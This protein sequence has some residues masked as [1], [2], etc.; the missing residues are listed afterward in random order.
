MSQKSLQNRTEQNRTEQNRTEQNR[1]ERQL[2]LRPRFMAGLLLALLLS[3]VSAQTPDANNLPDLGASEDNFASFWPN[4]SEQGA[5]FAYRDNIDGKLLSINPQYTRQIGAAIGGSLAGP[6]SKSMAVGVLLTGGTDKNEWLLNTGFDLTSNQRFILSIGQLRQ[7]QDFNFISGAQKTQIRQD[8]GAISYQYFLA[9][10]WLNAAELNAYLSNTGSVNLEDKTYFTD[11]ASLYELWSDPRRIAGG[12]IS[13]V[14]GHLVFTPSAKSSIKLGFGGERLSYDYVTGGSSATRATGSAEWLQRLDDG[15]NFRT[16]ANVGVSQDRYTLGLGKSFNN[17]SQLGIDITTIQGRDNSFN[18]NQLQL[19]YTQSFGGNNTGALG[20][21]PYA[22][23]AVSNSMNS[24]SVNVATPRPKATNWASSLINQVSR[25][26]SFLPARVVAKIDP[27]ATPTRLIVVDKTALP[28]NSSIA[29]V[30]GI[31]AVPIGVSVSAIAGV[32]LNG[33]VFNNSGQYTLSGS[34][35]LVINPNLISQPATGVTDTYV[36][37]MN[38]SSGGGTTLAT[39]TVIHGSSRITS[40]VIS[41]GQLA[42][43]ITFAGLSSK[44]ATDA[45]FVVSATASSG[46]SVSLVSISTSVCTASSGTVTLVAPGSCSITAS[47]VGNSDYSAAT[48]VTQTFVVNGIAPSLSGL[49]L[50]SASVAFG[51]AAPTITAPTSASAGAISY[52]SSNT[53]VFSVSGSTITI[54][55]VGTA[56]LTA[57]QAAHGNYA[58]TTQTTTLTVIKADP[59]ISSITDM[60]I[61]SSEYGGICFDPNGITDCAVDYYRLSHPI[62]TSPGAFDMASSNTILIGSFGG[63]MDPSSTTYF[64]FSSFFG[65]GGIINT[66]PMT[67]IITLTQASTSN[68]NEGSVTFSITMIPD[69]GRSNYAVNGVLTGVAPISSHG[70]VNYGIDIKVGDFH[71]CLCTAAFAQQHCEG[72]AEE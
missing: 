13:G 3:P 10:D 30:T 4:V 17:G 8:N 35:H 16:S 60:T 27:T 11:T 9:K 57:T 59:I 46:L 26:P 14:Q 65:F 1:T 63:P 68:Y 66:P 69:N 53:A 58:S 5:G 61:F 34:T 20:N 21:T 56:T 6:L 25:R 43:T 45:P 71:E 48:S 49:A 36:V 32:T 23:D 28:L 29:T 2:T 39:I 22:L 41:S 64:T 38:N 67:S 47:Q 62:S 15:F 40:V 72:P 42:Q 44:L 55:G 24:P 7:K 51:A 12:R 37:T 18:D 33:S 54:V 19:T 52:S 31:L 50:S 70:C